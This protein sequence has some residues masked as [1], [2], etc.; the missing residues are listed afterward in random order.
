MPLIKEWS[1]NSGWKTSIFDIIVTNHYSHF[2]NGC[3]SF[4]FRPPNLVNIVTQFFFL[5]NGIF[6]S[7]LNVLNIFLECSFEKFINIIYRTKI[8]AFIHRT[9]LSSSVYSLLPDQQKFKRWKYLEKIKL[10]EIYL[11]LE[12][13]RFPAHIEY[14][15]EEK[16]NGQCSVSQKTNRFNLCWIYFTS[17]KPDIFFLILPVLGGLFNFITIPIKKYYV[18]LK[19]Y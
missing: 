7:A 6:Y 3:H 17:T 5:I 15:T 12:T 8:Y 11:N 9:D 10:I 4:L 13:Y 14:F 19:I 16:W 18:Q 2:I 1:T